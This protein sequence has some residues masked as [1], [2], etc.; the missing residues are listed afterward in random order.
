MTDPVPELRKDS[1]SDA[2]GSPDRQEQ[3]AGIGGEVPKLPA[4]CIPILPVRNTVLFPTV[5]LP[6]GAGRQRSIAAIQYAVRHQTPIGVLLQRDP[7]QNDPGPSDFYSIGTVGLVLRY[8]T[9]RDGGHQIICRG[10]QRFRV[11]D[12]L[13]GYP[14][15]AARIERIAEPETRGSEVEARQLQLKERA[16]EALRLLPNVPDELPELDTDD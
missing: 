3:A 14:F 12:F 1:A 10:D 11:V 13:D 4:D 6:L 15:L 8:V 9:G 7:E 5:V 2:S 16:I